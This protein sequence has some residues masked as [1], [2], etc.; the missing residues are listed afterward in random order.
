MELTPTS[1]EFSTL[2]SDAKIYKSTGPVLLKQDKSEAIM[3]VNKRIEFIE[4]EMY[5]FHPIPSHPLQH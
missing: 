3:N 1:Q 4:S 2:D 5:S